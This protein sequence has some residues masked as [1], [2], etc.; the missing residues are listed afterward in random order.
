MIKTLG[1]FILLGILLTILIFN[2]HVTLLGSGFLVGD[3]T[4]VLTYHDLVKEAEILKVKFP[5]EDDIEA[6]VL[7]FD[8][9][10]NLAILKLK[11]IPKVKRQ[12][13]MLSREGLG[14]KSESVF[15]LGYPWT[16]TLRDQHVLIEGVSGSTSILTK[17]NM[18]LEPVHSGGPLFN[19]KQEVVGMV[20][21]KDHAKKAFPAEGSNH[22]AIPSSFL[23]KALQGTR[24]NATPNKKK[25]LTREAFILKSRNNIVL[26]EA[27]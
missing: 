16:N 5:N 19:S 3:G 8:A 20:L 10:T 15:T 14:A 24:I 2:T 23:K 12:P 18:S 25:N 1:G 22:F 17:L 13:L 11:E 7:S 9:T 21:W 4:H 27:R 26:I 6:A